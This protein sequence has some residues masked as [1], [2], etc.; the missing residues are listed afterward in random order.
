MLS[1]LQHRLEHLVS[2]SSQLIFVSGDTIGQQQRTLEAF[3]SQQN[4]NAL[5]SH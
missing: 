4:E 2:Y 5:K 1:E 3:L